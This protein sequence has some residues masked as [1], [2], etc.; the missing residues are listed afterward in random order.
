MAPIWC[1]ACTQLPLH[2]RDILKTVNCT[3]LCHRKGEA[4]VFG[5][6]LPELLI[7]LVIALIVVGP[8]KLPQAGASIGKAIGEF[9]AAMDAS[10]KERK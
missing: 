10:A 5:L 1:A 9:R 3:Q 6:G 7:I 8:G 4:T 2:H